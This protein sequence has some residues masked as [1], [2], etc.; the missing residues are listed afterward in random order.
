MF[1]PNQKHQ[2]YIN[3]E[4]KA[5]ADK[6]N[7]RSM[8]VRIDRIINCPHCKEVIDLKQLKEKQQ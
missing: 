4:H 5:V 3:K 7:K 2:V 1:Y 8:V 6:N